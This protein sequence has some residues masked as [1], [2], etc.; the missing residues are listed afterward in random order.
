MSKPLTIADVARETG[1]T[2]ASLR[3]WEQRY[4]FPRPKRDAAGQRRYE[5]AD[6]HAVRRVITERASGTTLTASIARV[7][8]QEAPR[9]SG[10][11][12]ARLLD[13]ARASVPVSVTRSTMVAVSH[14]VEDECASRTEPGLLIGAFQHPRFYDKS[15]DRWRDLAQ[16]SRL[17]LVFADFEHVV[18]AGDEP[19]QIPL[20]ARSPL[21]REW[22]IVHLAAEKTSVAFVGRER[23]GSRA[24]AQRTFELAWSFDIGLIR[25][26]VEAAADNAE[27]T[28]PGV[29]RALRAEMAMLA[30]SATVDPGF[31]SALTA[32]VIGYLG[33]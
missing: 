16:G 33:K 5:Q 4:G 17:T 13:D 21:E 30:G 23:V 32:R 14:A 8:A 22:A 31:A 6:V 25:E 9:R 2:A 20:V 19:A 29:A 10:S 26:L 24:G 3:A 28:A 18:D 12:F 11:F 7:Q 1:L 15:A 27:L